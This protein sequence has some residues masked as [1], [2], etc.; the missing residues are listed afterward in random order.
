MHAALY[1]EVQILLKISRF[2]SM[3]VSKKAGPQISPAP[4]KGIERQ[5][6]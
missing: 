6:F 4:S 2:D 1:L 3:W 5:W